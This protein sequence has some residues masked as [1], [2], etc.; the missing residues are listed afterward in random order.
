MSKLIF[1]QD[2]E[3]HYGQAVALSDHITRITANNPSPF[4][5]FGTNTYLIGTEKLA[6]VDPGPDDDQHLKYIL[7]AIGERRLTHILVTH[8][9]NDHSPLAKKLK[10]ITGAPI[11]AEGVHRPSRALRHNEINPLDASS[12]LAFTADHYLKHGEHIIG[13]GWTV[14][15]VFTPGHCANHCAYYL[16]EDK[17]LLSGDLIMAWSTSI[18]APPD[19]S[20]AQYLAS[21]D[22]VIGRKY[23][24]ILPAHG[25]CVLSPETYLPA[26]KNHR[27]KREADILAVIQQHGRSNI[28]KIVAQLYNNLDPKLEYAAGLSVFA[29]IEHLIEQGKVAAE[30]HISLD[31]VYA[32]P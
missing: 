14:E 5:Y 30:T 3:P 21:L 2:F 26:L 10:E 12:D 8:T 4:T 19:G 7:A 25:P 32:C 13:D 20:M 31:G 16:L 9:H 17:T 28:P 18:I 29:H 23:A 22:L 11:F 6:I 15:A 27:M 1:N 24:T